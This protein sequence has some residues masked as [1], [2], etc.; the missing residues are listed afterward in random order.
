M[1]KVSIIIPVYN[2]EKFI[3]EALN[4]LLEQTFQDIE[5]VCVNDC[6]TDDTLRILNKFAKKD[7]RIRIIN[8]EKNVGVGVARNIGIDSINS[9]FVTFMDADD[10][11]QPTRIS[12]LYNVATLL[13]L[14]IVETSFTYYRSKPPSV[15]KRSLSYCSSIAEQVF[16]WQLLPEYLLSPPIDPWSKLFRTSL[17]KDNDIR[18]SDSCYNEVFLFTIKSRFFAKRMLFLEL[19]DYYY[20]KHAGSL[21]SEKNPS[22]VNLVSI[23]EEARSFLIEN[24]VFELI[25]KSFNEYVRREFIYAKNRV[26]P[27]KKDS[28]LKQ[29]DEYLERYKL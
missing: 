22:V 5:I 29:I 10:W 7:S 15:F 19:Y 17:L 26:T 6:S 4:S 2:A 14:D 23:F 8:L 13:N 11:I 1:A 21:I 27:D 16:N 28:L 3:E 9:E 12:N 20:R 24:G 18:F 25:E